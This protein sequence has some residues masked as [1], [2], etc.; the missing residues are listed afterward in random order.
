MLTLLITQKFESVI[1]TNKKKKYHLNY[2]NTKAM[3]PTRTHKLTITQFMSLEIGNRKQ[4]KLF[5]LPY[6][7]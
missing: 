3:H 6:I 5:K 2:G 1:F 7:I 4:D